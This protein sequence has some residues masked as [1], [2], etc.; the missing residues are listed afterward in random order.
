MAAPVYHEEEIHG[1]PVVYQR[2]N[3]VRRFGIPMRSII[4]HA[5]DGMQ[6]HA[7]WILTP[8]LH[9]LI[10]RAAIPM[11]RKRATKY[12]SALKEREYGEETQDGKSEDGSGARSED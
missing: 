4:V 9:P 12:L 1:F 7:E 6:Y 5:D 11:L 8:F 2:G 10:V 3:D